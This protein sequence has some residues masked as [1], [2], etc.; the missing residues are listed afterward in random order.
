MIRVPPTALFF[1]AFRHSKKREFEGSY[2][3]PTVVKRA[4]F[5]AQVFCIPAPVTV[6]SAPASTN[7][8]TFFREENAADILH[9]FSSPFGIL[10]TRPNGAVYSYSSRMP[11]STGNLGFV[12]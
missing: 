12:I 2:T 10:I 8:H 11:H 5:P 7:P 6:E 1:R 3:H 4:A 9:A